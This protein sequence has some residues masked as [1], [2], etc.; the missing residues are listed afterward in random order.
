MAASE[1]IRVMISSRSNVPVFDDRRALKDV[2]LALR[3]H[4]QGL[5]WHAPPGPDYAE[6]LFEVWIHE[7]DKGPSA[8]LSTFE[9]SLKR[10]AWAHLVIVLYTGEAGS[11]R[12]GEPVGICHAELDAAIGHRPDIVHMVELLPLSTSAERRDVD[13]RTFVGSLQAFHKQ[14][15]D[16]T[17]LLRVVTGMLQAVVALQVQRGSVAGSRK[18]DRG[19]ALEWRRL[20]MAAR[21][22][23]MTRALALHLEAEPVGEGGDGR[24]RQ[25]PFGDDRP[26]GVVLDAIAGATS[27]ASAR[28]RVGQP[29]LA[30]HRRAGLLSADDLPGPLHIVACQGS[31]TVTQA[32][33][34]LGSSDAIAVPTEFGAYVADRA[35]KIQLFFLGACA[36]L[37]STAVAVR[38]L[39]AWLSDAGEGENVLIRARARARILH[40]VAANY[41]DAAPAPPAKAPRRRLKS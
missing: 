34:I 1:L 15:R 10:V 41:E 21:Q 20:D 11:A 27:D 5:R 8:E 33:R 26:V 16:E 7:D 17:E 36:D 38:R 4:I 13:F 2:R 29:F 24:L 32:L 3:D 25:M 9:I 19:A 6:P 14:A 37:T 18:G 22:Q 31:V 35:Q 28:E 39:R 23:A 40:T 12:R 30:D